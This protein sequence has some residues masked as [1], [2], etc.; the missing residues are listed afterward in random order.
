MMTE[1]SAPDNIKL[2]IEGTAL[3]NNICV[4]V[5]ICAYG[6]VCVCEW[7]YFTASYPLL[8]SI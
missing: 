8:F 1:T 5:D 2:V 3:E 7:L 6:C 4:Y